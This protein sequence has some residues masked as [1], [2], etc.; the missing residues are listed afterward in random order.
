MWFITK[1]FITNML[2]NIIFYNDPF[3]VCN[4]SILYCIFSLCYPN[5]L[6]TPHLYYQGT[7]SS[8]FSCTV[9]SGGFMHNFHYALLFSAVLASIYFSLG[10]PSSSF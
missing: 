5:D 1:Q 10:T 7:I 4:C 8:A 6:L 2:N 3:I 9:Y